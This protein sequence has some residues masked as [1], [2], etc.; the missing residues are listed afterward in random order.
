MNYFITIMIG[1][2]LCGGG[3]L[4]AS[5]ADKM[6]QPTPQAAQPDAAPLLVNLSYVYRANG[7][8][9]FLPIKEGSVLHS[10]DHYK[11]ILTASEECHIY[12]F[13]VDSANKIFQLFPMGS[14]GGVTLNNFNP[15]KQ[16][17]TVYIPAESKSFEL[18]AQTGAEKIYFLASRA[19]NEELETAYQQLAEKQERNS[20]QEQLA[21]IDQL[22]KYAEALQQSAETAERPESVTWEEN[23]QQFSAFLQRLENVRDGV[24][25]VLTF[26]HR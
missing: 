26:E 16:G 19:R 23:G 20:L 5:V 7:Q 1:I 24:S 10:G 12:I 15:V 17:E 13:Q 8:G 14:F 9:E 6:P 21:A 3:M 22:L 18:D 25:Y 2:L 4:E 11:L